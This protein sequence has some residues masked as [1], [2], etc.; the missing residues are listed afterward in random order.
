MGEMEGPERGHTVHWGCWIGVA[1]VIAI[2]SSDMGYV[3]R[4]LQKG[5]HGVEDG[6]G[7]GNRRWRGL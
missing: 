7:T 3:G 4:G 6:G 5:D 1:R 2:F